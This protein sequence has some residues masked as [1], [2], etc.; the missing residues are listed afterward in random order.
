MRVYRYPLETKEGDTQR[1]L[2][3]TTQD[4]DATEGY[5]WDFKSK[6]EVRRFLLSHYHHTKIH[7][8]EFPDET[9]PNMSGS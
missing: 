9:V 6:E 4:P 3:T 2:Y 5:A 1:Y 7:T 8:V